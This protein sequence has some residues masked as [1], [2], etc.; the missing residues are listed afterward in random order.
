MI[1]VVSGF[2]EWEGLVKLVPL[3]GLISSLVL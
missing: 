3:L 2:L 1:G